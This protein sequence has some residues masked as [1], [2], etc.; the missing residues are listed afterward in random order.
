MIRST[1]KSSTRY[2]LKTG[3]ISEEDKFD[4]LFCNLKIAQK[5]RNFVDLVNQ[6]PGFNKKYS[7]LKAFHSIPLLNNIKRYLSID[8]VRETKN[9]KYQ[10]IVKKSPEKHLSEHQKPSS[11]TF[12]NTH[13]SPNLF[14]DKVESK[15]W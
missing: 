8:V 2:N 10:L 7:N 6:K 5:K 13:Q 11:K 15:L 9:N 12:F 3:H 4:S 1:N 14:K